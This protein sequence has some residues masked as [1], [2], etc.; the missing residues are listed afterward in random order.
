M[1]VEGLKKRV[2]HSARM[3]LVRGE[4]GGEQRLH[5]KGT[6]RR[7]PG[8]ASVKDAREQLFIFLI[9]AMVTGSRVPS[10]PSYRWQNRDFVSG[11][12]DAT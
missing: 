10:G 2:V 1:C 12:A 5:T 4:R 3:L 11:S 7:G 9:T 8:E 6:A